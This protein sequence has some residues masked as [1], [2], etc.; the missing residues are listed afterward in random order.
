MMDPELALLSRRHAVS[1]LLTSAMLTGSRNGSAYAS[2]LRP[3]RTAAQRRKGRHTG[4]AA[5]PWGAKQA[6]DIVRG[7]EEA[8]RE[9]VEVG[10]VGSLAGSLARGWWVVIISAASFG[11]SAVDLPSST[12]G[13]GDLRSP[14]GTI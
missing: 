5:S 7:N 1:S 4:E 2:A 6:C 13:E 11:C 14:P 8:R 3:A 12:Q 10:E 9:I